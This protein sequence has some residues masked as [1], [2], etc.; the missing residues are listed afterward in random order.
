MYGCLF[1][2]RVVYDKHAVCVYV[3]GVWVFNEQ[4]M[5]SDIGKIMGIH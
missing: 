4:K 5:F 2:E 1:M 3:C